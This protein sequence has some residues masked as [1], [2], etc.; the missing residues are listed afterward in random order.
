[1]EKEKKVT[2]KKTSSKTKNTKKEV[3]TVKNKKDTKPAS[4]TSTKAIKKEVEKAP[5]KNEVK[6]EVKEI[7]KEEKKKK[8]SVIKRFKTW[9]QNLPTK[10]VIVVCTL[11]IAILLIVLI[12]ISYRNTKLK[13]GKEIVAKVDGK[14][15]TADDLYSTLKESYGSTEV[16]NAIDDY[17]INKEVKTTDEMRTAAQSTVD[18]YK[19]NYGDQWESFLSY[20]GAKD[21][22]EF[23]EIVIKQS[24]LSTITEDYIK[25]TLTEKEMKAYYETDIYGDIKA[26]HILIAVNLEDDATED[27]KTKAFEDAKKKAEEIIA[28]LNKGEKFADLAKKYSEDE[29]TKENGGDLGYFNT[30]QMVKEFEEAAYKLKTN[31]YTT[32]PVKTTYGYHVILKTDQKDKPSYE[33]AKDTIIEKITEEKV[34]EDTTIYYKALVNLRKKYNLKIKDKTVKK[35]Y[36]KEVEENTKVQ[37]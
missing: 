22:A 31:K 15:I 24:K 17:L 4:K 12:G 34:A 1:M 33:D 21:E 2:T 32:S 8:E 27:E 6:L 11:I 13:N 16:I 35:A 26:S 9:F 5:V 19:S 14:T 25:E 30:G 20:Y 3:K 28:K 23:K 7:K 18:T 10:N 37:D 29:G 36:N